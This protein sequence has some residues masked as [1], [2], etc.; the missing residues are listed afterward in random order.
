MFLNC[1]AI[2]VSY[3]RDTN[4]EKK[5]IFDQYFFIE[6]LNEENV[7][8]ERTSSFDRKMNY[9]IVLMEKLTILKVLMNTLFV[10]LTL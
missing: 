9:F 4:L 8:R 7:I 10:Y 3:V 6:D 1:K 5:V 2:L